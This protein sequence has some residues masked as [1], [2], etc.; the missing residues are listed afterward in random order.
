MTATALTTSRPAGVSLLG[1]S[2]FVGRPASPCRRCGG[3]EHYVNRMGGIVCLTCSPPSGGPL[4]S[5]GGPSGVSGSV[6]RLTCRGGRWALPGDAG[7]DGDAHGDGDAAGGFSGGLTPSAPLTSPSPS[8]PP[9]RS[10]IRIYDW[11]TDEAAIDLAALAFSPFAEHVGWN[12]PI[13]G[14]RA[15][16]NAARGR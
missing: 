7:G 8:P 2:R 12:E 5:S 16:M 4:A 10:A 9:S 3:A 6:E 13:T 14:C 11:T 1:V 15:L